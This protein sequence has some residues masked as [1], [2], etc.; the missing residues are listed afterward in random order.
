M[1]VQA[2]TRRAAAP[3]LLLAASALPGCVAVAIPIVAGGAMVAR[4][5]DAGT[6]SESTATSEPA[7]PAP[8]PVAAAAAAPPP[9]AVAPPPA[10]SANPAT[11]VPLASL[12]LTTFDPAFALFAG[13]ALSMV[14]AHE[15]ARATDDKEATTTS[16]LLAD[17]VALDGERAPCLADQPT[18]VLIDLD[19]AGGAFVPP[20]LATPL[21]EH[22]AALASL[23]DG[24]IIIGWVSQNPATQTGPIRT[25][26]EQSGLDPRGQDVLLLIAQ[27]D[28]RKQSLR[29]NF[30]RSACII[31]IAGDDRTDFDE[32]FRYLRNPAAGAGL[33]RLIGD[34]WHL[35]RPI[36]PS[37]PSTGTPNP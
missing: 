10:L 11:R 9:M 22:A 19:P 3:F 32:R 35:V 27:E 4:T 14:A 23:R 6:K 8:A 5:A 34:A 31:A 1:A 21:P 26:L 29:E 24:G 36:F 18:A 33:D 17:P 12:Q 37:N 20:P 25:A 16:A 2:F 28:G 7:A 30:A 13:R 15:E